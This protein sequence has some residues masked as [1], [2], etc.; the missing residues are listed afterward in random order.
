V[1]GRVSGSTEKASGYEHYGP[2]SKSE[3]D[4]TSRN[5]RGRSTTSINAPGITKTI[6]TRVE[7][8]IKKEDDELEL[9]TLGSQS[10][11]SL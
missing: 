3:Q 1:S 8:D 10:S 4:S 11:S 5:L 7:Y 6:A 9:V 2:Q